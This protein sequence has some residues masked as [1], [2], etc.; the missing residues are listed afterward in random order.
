MAVRAA[1]RVTLAVLPAP[2]Y[3][4]TYY[5]KQA[6][7]L[8]PPAAPTTNPPSAPWT[9]VEPAYTE[10]STD[11]LY[12]VMLVAYGSVTFEYG[13][14]QK[15][16]SFEAA[17]QAYNKATSASVAAAAVPR[18][19]HSTAAPT[20]SNKAPLNSVWMRH[21]A[22]VTGQPALSGPVIAQYTQTAASDTGSTWTASDLSS[23]VIANLDLGKLTVGSAT[24]VESVVEKLWADVVKAKF[25][26][27]TEKII[28]KDVIADGAV[29]ARSIV[30]SESMW[31]KVL[32]T[33]KVTALEADLGTFSADE[34]FVADMR[35]GVLTA[36]AF[37]GK[38]FTGGTFTG[39]TF[40]TGASDQRL[41][42]DTAGLHAHNPNGTPYFNLDP[43]AGGTVT[44]TLQ[45]GYEPPAVPSTDLDWFP[46]G[47]LRFIHGASGK[48]AG[49]GWNP[50]AELSLMV[51][52]A[53]DMDWDWASGLRV[54]YGK[55]YLSAGASDLQPR[56]EL[57]TG[58]GQAILTSGAV[59]LD[60]GLG[61][62]EAIGQLVPTSGIR[63]RSG[64]QHEYMRHSVYGGSRS[65][66]NA[67]VTEPAAW[68]NEYNVGDTPVFTISGG[69]LIVRETGL[70]A[71]D[72]RTDFGTTVSGRAFAQINAGGTTWRGA[73]GGE[74]DGSVSATM[75]LEAGSTV[76]LQM[77]QV[78]G[79][80]RTT[81]YRANVTRVD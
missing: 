58:L 73:F 39:P 53:A 47:T 27:V 79:G 34:G 45:P 66:S 67:T 32:G 42:M 50:S 19:F 61:A 77:Y 13:P 8:N 41:Q 71:I 26:T 56:L 6:S 40:R 17:K 64:A 14:V 4:R 70:Y 44:F 68:N 60:L 21:A 20:T 75:Y 15:S 9:T 57:N 63:F 74:P 33:H 49:M 30:A 18:I 24:I 65:V 16:S 43:T 78:S 81:V 55:V 62:I 52:P 36:T 2:S 76:I 7:T 35:A 22:P 69:R 10:G 46:R 54:D 1:D 23:E 3:V 5:L 80:T 25:L 37:N 31:T 38:E 28:T 59:S 11:T 48:Q 51:V 29:E 72:F 12:T